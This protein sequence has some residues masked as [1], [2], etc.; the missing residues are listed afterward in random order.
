[1]IKTCLYPDTPSF[2]NTS[3]FAQNSC[4]IPLPVAK[5]FKESAKRLKECKS[6]I[7][8]TGDSN[9]RPT[10]HK[11]N[12]LTVRPGRRLTRMGYLLLIYPDRLQDGTPR[13]GTH[14][15]LSRGSADFR[16]GPA[17]LNQFCVISENFYGQGFYAIEND[18]NM[19]RLHII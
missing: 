9:M 14:S 1:M 5:K 11:S 6:E 7:R 8:P 2:R 10:G 15:Y 4:R 17:H 3:S 12:T 16:L 19:F 13:S 18:Q